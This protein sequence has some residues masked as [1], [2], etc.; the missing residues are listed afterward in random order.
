METKTDK[1]SDASNKA[2]TSISYGRAKRNDKAGIADFLAHVEK[3]R[4]YESACKLAY[5]NRKDLPETFEFPEEG[6]PE[7]VKRAFTRAVYRHLGM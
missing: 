2:K 3:K 5:E 6:A 4:T 7:G 1:H